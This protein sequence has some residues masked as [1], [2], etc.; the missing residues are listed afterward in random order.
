MNAVTPKAGS[1]TTPPPTLEQRRAQ[2]AWSCV[3]DGVGKD[4]VRVA[5]ATPQLVMNSG[6]M[7]TLAFME[8]KK[9]KHQEI[10]KQ[11]CAWLNQRFHF[12]KG[13]VTFVDLMNKLLSAGSDDFRLYTAEALAWLKWLRQFAAA[14]EKQETR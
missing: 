5:K 11:L 4:Y 7:Q 12:A 6:L 3:K 2:H 14:T 1:G 9:G 13:E 8:Q 10:A